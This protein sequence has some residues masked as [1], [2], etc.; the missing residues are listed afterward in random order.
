[1]THQ[2]KGSMCC[3]CTKQ[4]DNCSGLPFA[5]MPVIKRY[6]DGTKAVKCQ[7]FESS[8]GADPQ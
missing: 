8:K 7:A 1:M 6:P 4:R 5:A 2:P 3:A